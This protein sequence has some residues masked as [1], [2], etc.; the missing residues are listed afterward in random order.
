[1]DATNFRETPRLRALA[2]RVMA[3]VLGDRIGYWRTRRLVTRELLQHESERVSIVVPFYGVEDYLEECLESL[4]RQSYRNFEVIMVDDGSLDGSRSI[5]RE[6]RKRD[7]RFKLLSQRNAGLGAARN[8]GFRKTTGEYVIFVDSDDLVMPNALERM[9]ESLRQSGSDFVVAG[10]E[11]FAEESTWHDDWVL[12]VHARDQ[13]GISIDEH[14]EVTKNVYAWSKLYRREFF[15]R[16]IGAYPTDLLNEDQEPAARGFALS[17][18]FDVLS[19]VTYR[20]RLRRDGSSITQNRLREKNLSDRITA[21][22]AVAEVYERHSS[23]TVQEY[24]WRDFVG[25]DFSQFYRG[26]WQGSDEYWEQVSEFL[27]DL[28]DKLPSHIWRGVPVRERLLAFLVARGDRALAQRMADEQL[29]RPT[30]VPVCEGE[31]G[32]RVDTVTLGFSGI[33]WPQELLPIYEIDM[34]LQVGVARVKSAPGSHFIIDAF[35]Y[36]DNTE[37]SHAVDVRVARVSEDRRF[38]SA[39]PFTRFSF[40]PDDPLAPRTS[41]AAQTHSGLRLLVEAEAGPAH[42]RS[43][44]IEISMRRGDDWETVTLRAQDGENVPHLSP[45]CSDSGN[46]LALAAGPMREIQVVERQASLVVERLTVLKD[47]EV[48]ICIS[49]PEGNATPGTLELYS[50]TAPETGTVVVELPELASYTSF[51]TSFQLPQIAAVLDSRLDVR[52]RLRYVTPAGVSW[53]PFP[54]SL[55]YSKEA[56]SVIADWLPDSGDLVLADMPWQAFVDGAECVGDELRVTGRI[57][58]ARGARPLLRL[59]SPEGE[60][61]HPSHFEASS[62]DGSF[63]AS[64][65]PSGSLIPNNT[66][67]WETVFGLCLIASEG[68]NPFDGARSAVFADS[69]SNG[70]MLG[71]QTSSAEYEVSDFGF[72]RSLL[73]RGK[74][75]TEAD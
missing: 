49:S 22:L 50:E 61:I 19:G 40:D 73:V 59:L 12:R 39:V 74:E 56:T 31:E 66:T 32:P 44:L 34:P 17:Q 1:M 43:E 42:W 25:P 58:S 16:V 55:E 37:A 27:R 2:G 63:A 3:R 70:L 35:A 46:V 75:R 10:F 21:E 11:H 65:V 48:E 29:R 52:W 41:F 24:R 72:R 36:F 60:T 57:L 45:I 4:G 64:F 71:W 51:A 23:R 6:W 14:L 62:E 53:I 68:D 67:G 15:A 54:I 18:S 5:A 28:F 38:S 7:F 9:V 13:Q 20:W 26:A 69:T 8:A 47:R 30:G 33:S